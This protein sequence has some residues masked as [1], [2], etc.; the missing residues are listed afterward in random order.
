ML[1]LLSIL[2][3]QVPDGTLVLSSK[4]GTIIGNVANRMATKAQ[5]Y[6]AKYTHIGIVL[7]GKVYHSDYPRVT[8]RPLNSFKRHEQAHYSLPGIPYSAQQLAT[9]TKYANSQLGQ[10]YRLRGFIRR[11]G[12]EG[13]SS[14]FV[15][16]VLNAGGHALTLQDRFTP[17]N[18]YR[19]Y[20]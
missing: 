6:P 15:G 4:P 1:L 18:V 14:T 3:L 16:Q 7:E 11:N 12:S 5:G 17:D 10:P 13:W 2:L 20:R 9:K 19:S 8:T